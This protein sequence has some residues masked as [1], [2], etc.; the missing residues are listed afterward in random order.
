MIYSEW[1]DCNVCV[2]SCQ[3][4]PMK[5]VCFWMEMFFPTPWV[6]VRSAHVRVEGLT[7]IRHNA[8]SLAVMH[9]CLGS[10]ARTTAMVR[11]F[12]FA[13]RKIN[14]SEKLGSHNYNIACFTAAGCSYV[15][16]E[17]SN[18]QQFPHP[19]DSCRTCSCTVRIMS[20]TPNSITCCLL[21]AGFHFCLCLS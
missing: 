6:C 4:A 19:T 10:A 5:T 9:R 2:C 8:L 20:T 14:N 11:K 16:K 7:A 18:G 3:T 17:Y 12:T 13:V 21:K 15:G 1:G